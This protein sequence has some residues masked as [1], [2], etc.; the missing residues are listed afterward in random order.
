M[1][2]AHFPR[3]QPRTALRKKPPREPG[4]WGTLSPS[5]L[6]GRLVCSRERTLLGTGEASVHRP[7]WG[8]LGDSELAPLR[9]GGKRP[10]NQLQTQ[11]NRFVCRAPRGCSRSGLSR[12]SGCHSVT[13]V[14]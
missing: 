14:W 6:A 11:G 8:A 2:L 4:T 10:P 9:A 7:H 12:F 13:Q 3:S 5:P 1:V